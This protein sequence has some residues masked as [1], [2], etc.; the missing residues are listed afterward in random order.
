[1]SRQDA[2]R[3]RDLLR[4]ANLARRDNGG[5]NLTVAFGACRLR[6]TRYTATIIIVTLR[7]F[8]FILVMLASVNRADVPR[9]ES[10]WY[11]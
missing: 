9:E 1:M 3:H 10:N 11:G 4:W 2:V 8:A 6:P 5:V 7:Y